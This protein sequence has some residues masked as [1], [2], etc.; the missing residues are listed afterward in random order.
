MDPEAVKTHID[1][2]ACAPVHTRTPRYRQPTQTSVVSFA[3]NKL[4]K[5]FSWENTLAKPWV[6]L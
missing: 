2:R 6:L 5:M 4:I 1:I 3:I